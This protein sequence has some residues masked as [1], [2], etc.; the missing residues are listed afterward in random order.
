M[1]GFAEEIV[2]RISDEV[3][4]VVA[5][6]LIDDLMEELPPQLVQELRSGELEPISPEEGIARFWKKH[7]KGID[8]K[9]Y[10]QY[11][12]KLDYL[13]E[14]LTS[15]LGLE[16]LN[17]LTPRQAEDYEEWRQFDSLDR[18]KPLARKTL[19]DDIHLYLAFLA[20]MTKIRA[21]PGDAYEAVEPVHLDEGEGVDKTKLDADRAGD[22]LAFLD[23]FQYASLEHVTMLLMSKTGRRPCDLRAPDLN[24]FKSKGDDTTLKFV[25]RPEEDTPLKENKAHE[26]KITLANE[27]GQI[28]QDYID[29]NRPDVTDEHGREPLLATSKGRISKS[30]IKKYSYKWTRPCSIGNGCPFGKDPDNCQAESAAKHASKCDASRSPRQIRSGYVTA[31]LN[32]GASYESVGFRVGAT[33]KVLKRHYDHPGKEKERERHREEIMNS[34]DDPSSGY[35]NG[36]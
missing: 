21:V 5:D 34:D 16:N 6:D 32:A 2:D 26:A 27:V 30:T 17:N 28:V 24:D 3:S 19:K 31:K 25:H 23:R 14:Y 36:G 22:I 7:R 1:E 18:E 12:T 20:H 4:D 29:H 8:E 33:K 13:E 11:E 10:A 15:E 35:S 9:C